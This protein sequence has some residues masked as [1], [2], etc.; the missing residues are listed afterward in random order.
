MDSYRGSSFLE[1]MFETM[2]E[3]VSVF[4]ADLRMVAVN[5]RFRE[6]LGFPESLCKPGTPFEMF[7]RYNV[8]Q[9]DY[10]PGD[11]EQQIR[12]RVA[13]AR[14][15]EPHHFE[16]ER[17]DG[18]ILEIRGRPLPGG[19]FVT[20]YADI[21][22]RARA[23]RELRK[24]N[25]VLEDTLA[26]MD[27]GISI[28]DSDLRLLAFNRKLY[29][30]LEFPEHLRRAGT[31]L[32]D[33]IRY[34]AERGEYGPGDI[35]EQVRQ[36]I[37]IARQMQPHQFTRARPD[38]TVLEIR[39]VPIP[40]GRGFVTTYTD[41]TKRAH[42]EQATLRASRMYAALG[43]TNEA[44]LRAKSPE[45]LYQR[46]CDAAVHGGK[47]VTTAVMLPADDGWA[48]AVAITSSGTGVEEISAARISVDAATP[49]GRGLVGTA[50]RTLRPCVSDDF[51]NDER[52]RPWHDMGRRS[53]IGSA[54]ALPLIRSGQAVGVLIFTSQ[55][56]AA[57]DPEIV[58]LL[59]RMAENAVFALE[60]LEHERERRH[61][62][63]AARQLG[64]M[65][66]ALSAT[67]EA[68]IRAKSPEELYQ[69]VCD[70]AVHGGQFVS[71]AVILAEP[72]NIWAR[73][74]AAT[75]KGAQTLRE[76]R[77]SIDE[78]VPEGRGLVGVVYRTQKSA[79]VNDF[80]SDER[81]RP[82]YDDARRIG[83]ASEALM[84]LFRAG[85]CIG[86]LAFYASEKDW[87][88]GEIV[89]LLEHMAEN[90][91][92]ALD[93]FDRE[94]ERKRAE[95]RI[96]HLAT[97]DALT[98]LPNRTLFNELL[99]ASIE[100]ARRYKRKFG[101]LFVDLDGFKL[102]NDTLGHEAGDA[103]L[104]EMGERFKHCLRASDV[105][106]RLGGDEF[107]V[108]LQEISD[109]KQVDQV[110][111][112]LLSAAIRPMTIQGRECRISASIGVAIYPDHAEN[113]EALLKNADTAMYAAKEEG[114]NCVQFSE[115]GGRRISSR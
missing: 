109:F 92:F 10:G 24:S 67:N 71:T 17:P 89:K 80:F 95:E 41:I 51:L 87:F 86:T 21:T 5:R 105:V 102:I 11:P 60:N 23:E 27:Q 55:E 96:E 50:F 15:F 88:N 59:E 8:E 83:L 110:A 43:A 66:A 22:K 97:H 81:L 18:T 46:L 82:W 3:G 72:G 28:F 20:V 90:V 52:T 30:V 106:A 108:L 63:Q 68:I 1:S 32:A 31:P 99:M 48:K 38:G 25:S 37:E 40:D 73:V 4:D 75:G 91:S 64:R 16:R 34:N 9:G 29:E 14:L 84:P 115:K 35:D 33:F 36:R 26:H 79:I 56:K 94:L 93:N 78:S 74:A 13:R 45:E 77:L 49:E 6:I 42:A 85:H 39:G 12:D 19:G 69:Q 101:L 47:F 65:Y 104:K 53:A 70:A 44:I 2:D 61:A 114:K 112:K 57:F 7:V 107:V 103:L 100:T 58:Q 98:E 111:Q 113:G 76:V 62:E 54:A